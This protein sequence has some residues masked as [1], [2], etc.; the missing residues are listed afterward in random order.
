MILWMATLAFADPTVDALEAELARN[1]TELS[2][3]GGDSPWFLGYQLE[4][5]EQLHVTASLG[6]I[7]SRWR[8]PSRHLGVRLRVGTP[9]VDSSHFGSMW[10]DRGFGDR[11]LG[12]EGSPAEIRR[13]AWLLADEQY[14]AAVENLSRKIASR[15]G[16][17]ERVR[18]DDF[19]PSEGVRFEAP[20]ANF[21]EEVDLTERC[22][23]LSAV[24]LAHPE[25][26]WSRSR[27][28]MGVGRT[29]LLD[30]MGTR[31][32]LPTGL[33]TVQVAGSIRSEEGTWAWDSSDWIVNEVGD[34]PSL[35]EMTV[36][37]EETALR[38]E[39]W[40]DAEPL[41]DEYAGPVLF[42]GEAAVALFSQLLLPQLSGTPGAD[43]VDFTGEI[44]SGTVPLRLKRRILPAGFDVVD[45]PGRDPSLPGGFTHD[46]AGVPAERVDVVVDGLVRNLLMSHVP[47]KDVTQTNG[48]GRGGVGTELTGQAS[49]MS[50]TYRQAISSKR[51]V[52]QALS[53]AATY[54]Q[55]YV[56]LVRSLRNGELEG[57][58][59]PN[60]FRVFSSMGNDA[61]ASLRAPLH[62][63][64]LYRDGRE[65]RIRDL[66]VGGAD[67]RTL[68]DIVAASGMNTRS[69]L[70]PVRP[71][72]YEKVLVTLSVPDV[73][74]S[75]MVFR[76]VDGGSR[77]APRLQSPLYGQE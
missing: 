55:N 36:E 62:V 2:I 29:V 13:A 21:P 9:E 59:S 12:I 18:P 1:L 73:L 56:L 42:S 26:A 7:I 4:E 64:R 51:L 5:S 40:A 53:L 52:K 14:K 41:V 70:Q 57:S 50:V 38:L 3:E 72:S 37:A 44:E 33:A 58:G 23:E 25:V 48:H 22:R 65:E 43:E 49:Q 47:N 54:D 69:F 67:A 34:L 68:R 11:K 15:R 24:F 8:G 28:V 27:C 16:R 19:A 61:A 77:E 45:D 60:F 31:V 63:V 30:S 6:G 46:D 39:A 20:T 76:P 74:V 66:E 75:E 71:D 32:I 35:D 10:D 17:V